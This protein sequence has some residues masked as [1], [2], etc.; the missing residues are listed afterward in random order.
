MSQSTIEHDSHRAARCATLSPAPLA[1]E[2]LFEL[3]SRSLG[4]F[5]EPR[6]TITLIATALML[7][8]VMIGGQAPAPFHYLGFGLAFLA[9]AGMVA[10]GW[11]N[12]R[13][14][15]REN[16]AAADLVGYLAILLGQLAMLLVFLGVGHRI[17]PIWLM[18]TIFWIWIGTLGVYAFAAAVPFVRFAL[19]IL[20]FASIPLSLLSM[21]ML[22]E[23]NAAR[24]NQAEKNA[25]DFGRATIELLEAHRR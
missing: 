25:Q 2:S 19:V 16:R 4:R 6:L 18:M 21:Q 20:F 1:N 3:K 17:L 24:K 13:K 5:F 7:A 22:Q 10:G 12:R 9:A 14:A 11:W 8:F 15:Q 23:R